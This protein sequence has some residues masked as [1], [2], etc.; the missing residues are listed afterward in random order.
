[1][2]MTAQIRVHGLNREAILA[3]PVR[4][5]L[6]Q[7]VREIGCRLWPKVLQQ[8]VEVIERS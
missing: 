1:M 7:P 5:F 6:S 8:P 2:L 4:E 3:Q